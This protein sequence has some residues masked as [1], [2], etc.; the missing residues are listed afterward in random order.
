MEDGLDAIDLLL[1]LHKVDDR[2]LFLFSEYDTI[3]L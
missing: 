3:V 2:L 1:Y